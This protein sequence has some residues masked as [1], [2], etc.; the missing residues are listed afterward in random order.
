MAKLLIVEDD[1]AQRFLYQEELEEKG[2][3][4]VLA[5]N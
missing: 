1:E 2:Y 5:K 3:K 4:V